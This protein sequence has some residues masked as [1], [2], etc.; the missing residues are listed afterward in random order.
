MMLMPSWQCDHARPGPDNRPLGHGQVLPGP[1]FQGKRDDRG[2]EK[3]TAPD[4]KL[5]LE[6]HAIV[7]DL[8]HTLVDP[9]DFRP[10][11]F[12]RADVAAEVVGLDKERFAAYWKD[13]WKLR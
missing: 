3:M 12:R 8:F 11:D 4:G 9:E 7:F 2:R 1:V 13:T 10:K 6:V 5:K